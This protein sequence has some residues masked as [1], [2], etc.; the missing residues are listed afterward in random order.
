MLEQFSFK[1]QSTHYALSTEITTCVCKTELNQEVIAPLQVHG[2]SSH[3]LESLGSDLLA[4]RQQSHSAP[5]LEAR[6]TLN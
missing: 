5:N 4:Q 2:Q 3:N 1:R 6:D